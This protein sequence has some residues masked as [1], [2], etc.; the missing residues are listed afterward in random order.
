MPR[1]FMP[2]KLAGTPGALAALSGEEVADA[3][4]RHVRGDWG[5][6]CKEDW[7]SNDNALKEGLRLFS[8]YA[9]PRGQRF[10]VITEADRS[11]TTILLPEEY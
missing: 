7:Q 9:S 5:L 6:V 2:G 8:V 4:V 10:F 11:V 1:L 3:L